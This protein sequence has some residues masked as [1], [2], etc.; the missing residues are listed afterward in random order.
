MIEN[1]HSMKKEWKI[2]LTAIMFL[3]RISVPHNIDHS[4]EYLQKAPKYFPLIGWIV[5]GICSLVFLVLS[6]YISLDTGILGSMIAG[7][8]TTGALHEDGFAD[9]CDGF[10][11]GWTRDKILSI[12]KD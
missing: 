12:M 1:Y 3:T 7:I 9:V 10:G 8:F 11:G 4:P 2:F 5:G 6:R